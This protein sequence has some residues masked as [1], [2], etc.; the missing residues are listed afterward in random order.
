MPSLTT[1][2]QKSEYTFKYNISLARHGWLRLTPAYSVKLVDEILKNYR[3][4]NLLVFDPFSGTGTTGIVAAMQGHNAILC[5]INPFLVWVANQKARNYT[6]SERTKVLEVSSKI[7][8]DTYKY[9]DKQNWIP[10]IFNIHRW[11]SKETLKIISALRASIVSNVDEHA[12]NK[13]GLI[14]IA[15]CR[16]II[17]TS[18]VAF[19][20]VSM[21]F[22]EATVNYE[23]DSV[24]NNFIKTVKSLVESTKD[25][26]IGSISIIH[27]DS[28][29][30]NGLLN[31]IGL[32]ITSPPY[33]NR[34]SYIRELRPYMY[35]LKYI[36]NSTDA[37][38][39]DWNTIG[40]TWGSATS[41]LL[42][43]KPSSKIDFPLLNDIVTRIEKTGKENSKLMSV[44]VYKYFSDMCQHIRNLYPALN[45][46]AK[47]Y[48]IIGNSTF[49]DVHVDSSSLYKEIF[50]MNGFSKIK[51]EII[52]KR[53][54][55]KELYEYC[56]SAIK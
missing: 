7:I 20:H 1:P 55:K 19:N 29:N 50:K 11:W 23:Y 25:D 13:F 47:I 35:W 6:E 28:R 48:Y 21:S 44:Y 15:F 52:R 49:F 2:K 37:S 8:L 26:I 16:I 56:V 5:E 34:I 4:H 53:N 14:W 22:N 42:S 3:M 10:S 51:S 9:I 33:P 32:V 12:C 54:C 39:I 38:Y 46:G 18:S 27:N 17:E 36:T 41:N 30:S 40:G 31:N 45:V 24:L 43:W